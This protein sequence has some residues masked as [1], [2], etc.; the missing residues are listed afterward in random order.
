MKFDV[1][2]GDFMT[3]S[4]A[5]CADQ[6]KIPFVINMPGPFAMLELLGLNL[7]NSKLQFSFFGFLC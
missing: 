7:S 3:C 5:L 1:L 6:L 4:A 2:I